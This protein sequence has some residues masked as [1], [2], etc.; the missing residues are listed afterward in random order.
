MNPIECKHY[1]LTS[2]SLPSRSHG[3]GELPVPA[4][5]IRIVTCHSD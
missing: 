3:L 4:S 5:D 2:S 1:Q